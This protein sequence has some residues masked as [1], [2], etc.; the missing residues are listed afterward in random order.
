MIACEELLKS[1][2]VAKRLA[3]LL[4]VDG[5]HVVVHP[6]L[7]H[8]VALTSHSLRYLALM[9]GEHKVHTT[10]MNVEVIAEILASHGSA[11]AVPSWESVAPWTWPSHDM[12][13]RSFLPQGKVHLIALLTHSIKFTAIIDDIIKISSGKN[14][15]LMVFVIFLN[16]EIYR[17][18]ALIGISICH[19]LLHE[20][21][22]LDDMSSGMRLDTRREHIERIHGMMIAVGVILCYLHRLKL[23]EACLLLNLVV[24]LVGIML[25]VTH[26]SDVTHIAHLISEM[27]EITEKDIE[28]NSR[29]GMSKVRIAI[30]C[31]SAD[32]HSD[33]WR[34]YRFE[35]L[36]LS[37]ER[38]I[39][40]KCLFHFYPCIINIRLQKYKQILFLPN[41]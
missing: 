7:H 20:F 29:T 32:I 22:L 12:L 17:T 5:N 9:M 25:K 37:A 2:K 13:G 28:C 4:S 10:S 21:F 34:M 8:R 30:Y 11:L 35:T 41:I 16:V 26:I 1:D 24:T 33:I 19:N 31:W 3:H 15:I 40:Q 38:V 23:F 39:N 6:I 18:V 14:T 27:L 36:L